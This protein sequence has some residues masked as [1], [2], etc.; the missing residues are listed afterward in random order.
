MPVTVTAVPRSF[1]D[2]AQIINQVCDGEMDAPL[3]NDG[4]NECK[5]WWELFYCHL[6]TINVCEGMVEVCDADN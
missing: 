4:F 5:Q 3:D 1:G 6:K 2:C